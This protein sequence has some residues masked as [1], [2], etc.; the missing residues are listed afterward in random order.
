MIRLKK[1]LKNLDEKYENYNFLKILH[2][3]IEEIGFYDMHTL[4]K[5][6]KVV[7]KNENTIAQL[8]KLGFDASRTHFTPKAI[9][10][11]AKINDIL[12]IAK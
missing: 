6:H 2:E 3:E 5:K 8:K 12:E 1:I 11:D 7:V 9:K 4:S 10:T